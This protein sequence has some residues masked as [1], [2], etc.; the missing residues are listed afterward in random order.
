MYNEYTVQTCNPG[1]VIKRHIKILS[2]IHGLFFLIENVI[3]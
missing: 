1:C 2:C 3:C